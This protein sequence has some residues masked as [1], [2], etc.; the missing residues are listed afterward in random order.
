MKKELE[1]KCDIILTI[2]II[3][4]DTGNLENSQK[5][6]LNLPE[7]IKFLEFIRNIF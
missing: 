7:R 6:L 3:Y 4:F 5:L 1:N 2:I